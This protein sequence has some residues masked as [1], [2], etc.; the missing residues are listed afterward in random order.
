VAAGE[1]DELEVR[2]RLAE[3][4]PSLEPTD[5]LLLFDITQSM[6]DVIGEV[7]DNAGTIMRAVRRRNPNSAFAV[8]SFADYQENLPWRL[9]QDVTDDLDRV[10]LA[11]GRLRLYDGKDLPEAY[12]RALNEAR[13]IGWR[14]GSRRFIVLFG[15]APAHDPNFFGESTGVDPGR[16]GV[17]GTNDDLRFAEVVR[18]LAL[19]RIT[20][21]ANYVPRDDKARK[22]FEFAAAQ[23]GGAAIP[24]RDVKKIPQAI[25]SAL[26][27][28]SFARPELTVQPEFADWVQIS[29][30][31]RRRV[32]EL[33]EYV[34]RVQVRV[35]PGTSDGVRRI[36]VFAHY[37][38]G[39]RSVDI[40]SAQISLLTGLRFHPVWRWLL[41][42]LCSVALLLWS[43]RRPRNSVRFLDN[44]H[45]AR[46]A[47][48]TCVLILAFALL[49]LAWRYLE[50]AQPLLPWGAMS[51]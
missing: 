8:A 30:G 3:D 22:G 50:G 25:V 37:D 40:G 9:D 35:P 42:A 45:F 15:D 1:S 26:D 51:A 33:R 49:H 36:R 41:I 5:V 44:G 31:Q 38:D 20:V 13:F 39:T 23:T 32:D 12:S 4:P 48:R 10:A 34:Y 28:Q 2:V 21:L 11:I 43:R 18:D 27:E 16:D 46:L 29:P 17:P 7:R 19:D 47:M 6:H 24:I 14:P